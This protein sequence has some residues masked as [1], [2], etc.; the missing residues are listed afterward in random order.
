MALLYAGGGAVAGATSSAA[1]G[2]GQG[3]CGRHRGQK[4]QRTLL[5]PAGNLN[6][7]DLET[8]VEVCLGLVSVHLFKHMLAL[9]DCTAR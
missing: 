2:A 6:H 9:M 1:T 4:A 5:P 3:R 8:F 7:F